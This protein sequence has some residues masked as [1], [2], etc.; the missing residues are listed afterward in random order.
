MN[1]KYL[2]LKRGVLIMGDERLTWEEIKHKYPHM[3]VG[4]V[5]IETG[6][7]S[8]SVKSA[9]VKYTSLETAYEELLHKALEGEITLLY[10]TLDED[11]LFFAP[12][13]FDLE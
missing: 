12:T 7:N 3:N 8:V 10:T 1:N 13:Q 11:D 2:I 9:V 6:I 4:L 5:D